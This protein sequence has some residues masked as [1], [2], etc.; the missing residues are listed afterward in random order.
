MA[1]IGVRVRAMES[2]TIIGPMAIL[3]RLVL[4]PDRQSGHGPCEITDGRSAI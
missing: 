4:V 3:R 2:N 1:T